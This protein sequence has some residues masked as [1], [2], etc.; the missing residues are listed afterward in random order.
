MKPSRHDT[1][2]AAAAAIKL[3][4]KSSSG[5]RELYNLIC[6]CKGGVRVCQ[7]DEWGG[8]RHRHRHT[9]IVQMTRAESVPSWCGGCVLCCRPLDGGHAHRCSGASTAG[10]PQP[11]GDHNN[12]GLWCGGTL[13]AVVASNATQQLTAVPRASRS[14]STPAAPVAYFVTLA[15]CCIFIGGGGAEIYVRSSPYSV[16]GCCRVAAV[17]VI[18]RWSVGAGATSSTWG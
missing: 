3:W 15:C 17:C 9:H 13:S 10:Q 4:Y 14:V 6:L 18:G 2:A 1:A 8:E 5:R 12:R 11:Q 16:D 7:C